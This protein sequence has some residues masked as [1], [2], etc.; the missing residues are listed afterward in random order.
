LDVGQSDACNSFFAIAGK[1]GGVARG[2][3]GIDL[4][5]RP[6]LAAIIRFSPCA[7]KD[8]GSSIEEE[9]TFAFDLALAT[10][11]IRLRDEQLLD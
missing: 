10:A 6:S 4:H 3:S 11:S 8:G 5:L 2:L 9:H 1:G 7:G